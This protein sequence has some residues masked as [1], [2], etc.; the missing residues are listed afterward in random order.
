MT[1]CMAAGAFLARLQAE[2][3]R[4]AGGKRNRKSPAPAD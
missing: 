2:L 4:A 3:R 1:L